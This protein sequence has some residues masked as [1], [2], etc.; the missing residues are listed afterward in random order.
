MAKGRNDQIEDSAIVKQ[1]D[2]NKSFF[3][4]NQMSVI[5]GA[6]I[7]LLII[8][9]FLAYQYLYKAPREKAASEQIFKAEQQFLRDSFAL[10]LEA[11]GGGYDGLLDIVDNYGGTQT[12]N[13]AKYYTGIS[14]LNLGRFEDA[15]SYLDSYSASGNITTI[16]KHGAMGDAYSEL[17][18]FS[19]ALNSY[20][21]ATSVSNDALTPYY[22]YK[23]GLLAQKEGNK[24]KA[25]KAF[26]RISGEFSKSAEA[27]DAAKYIGML[28]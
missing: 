17:G 6:A 4:A 20:E 25:L 18:D 11:P 13:L 10:A 14:Y 16:T 21:K 27:Q 12:A 8:G 23:M 9:A 22:L 7:V 24:D 5:T 28:N 3:E 19:K 15:I 2:N 26:K 1:A